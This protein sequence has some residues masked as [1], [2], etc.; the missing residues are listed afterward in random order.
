MRILHVT[1]KYP[2]AIGGDAGYVA[3]L[4]KEQS[5]QGHQVFILTA[6]CP[7]VV[8]K[9]N[10]FRFGLR[11]KARNWDRLGLKRILSCLWLVIVFPKF[12]FKC[13]P[14]IIHAHSQELG[15]IAS[16]WA[17]FFGI[18]VVL[19][20]HSVM[21]PYK[22]ED[23]FR[24]CMD[25][26]F[27][28]SGAFS[29]I[30]TVDSQALKHFLKRGFKNCVY[31]PVGVDQEVFQEI[32]SLRNPG[33]GIV[34]FLYVG[35]LER[36]K[37][38][39]LLLRSARALLEKNNNFEINIVGDGLL[40]KMLQAQAVELGLGPW[41]K[42]R[43]VINDRKALADIYKSS[44]IFVLPSLR[45]RFPLVILEAW[46]AR[47]ALI[48]PM[49]GSIPDVCTHLKDAYLV[50]PGNVSALSL[51]MLTLMEN[52]G[53]RQ[54]LAKNGYDLAKNKFSW[55]KINNDLQGIYLKI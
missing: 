45:E 18:P 48:A 4:E 51:A 33:N 39:G 37:G 25:Y 13:R 32:D 21:F 30:I 3:A 5:C 44:D 16:R 20:C 2:N 17:K 46:A 11:D 47:S 53:M 23:L 42:F 26:L 7:E 12:I 9:E 29:G 43:G 22:D 14:D 49:V 36:I 15:W 55:A 34:R 40:E 10:V 38:V 24:R 35:R 50:P 41:V 54:D 31:L 1:K 27:L 28:K 52:K 6:N 8:S 19:T